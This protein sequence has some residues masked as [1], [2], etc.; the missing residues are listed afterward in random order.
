MPKIQCFCVFTCAGM[1]IV[2]M[3]RNHGKTT[4]RARDMEKS[5]KSRGRE[6][7]FLVQIKDMLKK[8]NGQPSRIIKS[9]ERPLD[10]NFQKWQK[11]SL[12]FMNI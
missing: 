5:S 12:E 1:D 7:I 10:I 11:R 8:S 9:Q 6:N 3:D 4:T 2:G